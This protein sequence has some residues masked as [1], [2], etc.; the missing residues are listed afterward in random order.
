MADFWF[1]E[2]VRVRDGAAA[3]LLGA[4]VFKRRA[5]NTHNLTR[6]INLATHMTLA[7]KFCDP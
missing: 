4:K 3:S 7:E 2:S 1:T 6:A 5:H